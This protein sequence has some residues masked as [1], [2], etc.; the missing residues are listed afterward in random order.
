MLPVMFQSFI[1][2]EYCRLAFIIRYERYLVYS[3]WKVRTVGASPLV[4]NIS[5]LSRSF[6]EVGIIVSP[7]CYCMIL[8]NWRFCLCLKR[9]CFVLLFFWLMRVYSSG[10]LK[11]MNK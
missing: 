7:A 9:D 11:Q 1:L 10:D 6:K 8:N 2:P 5:P 3:S 4:V